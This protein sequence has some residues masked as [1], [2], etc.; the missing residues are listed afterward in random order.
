MT[1]KSI[2]DRDLAF[3]AM[4]VETCKWQLTRCVPAHEAYW[5]ER[6]HQAQEVVDALL[7]LKASIERGR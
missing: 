5:D 6:A 4:E 1:H 3:Y 7:K 2:I